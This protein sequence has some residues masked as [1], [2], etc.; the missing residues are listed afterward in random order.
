MPPSMATLA[1]A[2]F[3]AVFTKVDAVRAEA[4]SLL[5]TDSVFAPQRALFHSP[6]GAIG[7]QPGSSLFAGRSAG[8]LFAPVAIRPL[9][10]PTL[11]SALAGTQIERLRQLIGHAES[12]SDGY[13]AVQHGARVKPPGRP[14][15]LT[16][17]EIIAWIDAT[18]GQPH[19]IGKFQFIPP[20]LLRLVART[21]MPP[22][23]KFSPQVQ[24]RLADELLLEA[25][26]REVSSGNMGRHH[27]MGKLAMI[28]AGLPTADG[29]SYYD[30]YAG[31]K[32]SMTWAQYDTEMKRIFPG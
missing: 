23:T 19:A 25:G 18:P 32:A 27:F 2:L 11:G 13:D 21:G 14:T 6:K 3:I 24:D 10:A 1:L 20:T 30:G 22:T 9:S 29:K 7:Q 28:W 4:V 15:Q 5:T 17:G 8:G 16:I 31:N 12:R 26:L